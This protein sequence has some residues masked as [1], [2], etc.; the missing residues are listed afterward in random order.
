MKI[1][2][3]KVWKALTQPTLRCLKYI[4]GIFHPYAVWHSYFLIIRQSFYGKRAKSLEKFFSS[5]EYAIWLILLKRWMCKT[6]KIETSYIFAFLNDTNCRFER[7]QI[8]K[9]WTLYFHS[10]QTLG[11]SLSVAQRLMIFDIESKH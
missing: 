8:L 3:H 11:N 9:N 10:R 2:K 6:E 7:L 5:S 4:K 1:S